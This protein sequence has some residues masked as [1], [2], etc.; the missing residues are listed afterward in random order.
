MVKDFL[1]KKII[2]NQLKDLPQEQKEKVL[3][4]FENNP[5]FFG[6]IAEEIQKEISSGKDQF[7]AAMAVVEKNKEKIKEI[8]NN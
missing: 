3:K 8:L 2:E 4:A 5:E 6:R 1:L 7:S